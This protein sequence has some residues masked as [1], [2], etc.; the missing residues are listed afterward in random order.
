[1]ESPLSLKV[2]SFAALLSGIFRAINLLAGS[3]TMP[4]PTP[5]TLLLQLLLEAAPAPATAPASSRTLLATGAPSVALT[6]AVLALTALLGLFSFPVKLAAAAGFLNPCFHALA[7]LLDDDDDDDEAT[8]LE[9]E[10]GAAVEGADTSAFC[11][12]V[13]SA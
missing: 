1:L 10:A 6:A 8:V 5:L 9:L 12:R 11:L 2:P 4:P 7:S 3:F 13:G